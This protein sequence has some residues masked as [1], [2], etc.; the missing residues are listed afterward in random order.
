M[1]AKSLWPSWRPGKEA[2]DL[3]D[4]RSVRGA[5]PGMSLEQLRRGVD[6]ELNERAVGLG[7]IE[8]PLKGPAGGAGVAE[9]VLGDRVKKQSRHHPRHRDFGDRAV[10]DWCERGQRRLRVLLGEPQ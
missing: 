4:Q 8:R 6:Q 9:R 10:Q 5:L 7:D 1:S 3:G 2:Q